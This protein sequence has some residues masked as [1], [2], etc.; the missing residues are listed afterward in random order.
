MDWK[1]EAINDLKSYLSRKNSIVSMQEQIKMLE[2]KAERIKGFSAEAPVMGGASK[3]ED[4][5][6]NCIAEKDRLIINIEIAKKQ[7]ELID[8]GLAFL[9]ADER[10]VLTYFFIDR[11]TNH[12]DRLCDELGYEKTRI[13]ELKDQALYK[14][15]VAMYGIIDL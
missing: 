7:I 12:I 13:Y 4:V 15:T 5:L 1:E 10:L 3:S 9:N 8:C 14:F 11:P 2:A 6:I